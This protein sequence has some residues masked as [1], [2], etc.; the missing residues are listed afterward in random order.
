MG[1]D[2]GSDLIIIKIF[3]VLRFVAMQL[4]LAGL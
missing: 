4:C 3:V 2:E 1:L